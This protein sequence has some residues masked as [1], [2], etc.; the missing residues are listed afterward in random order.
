[1]KKLRYSLNLQLF[2]GEGEGVQGQTGVE[3]AA[4]EQQGAEG[5]S[6]EF[7]QLINGKFKSE[8]TKKTQAIIDKRFKS[9]KELEA[10]KQNVSPA[11]EMLMK[12]YGIP[13]GEEYRLS[14]A[15]SAEKE[16][17]SGKN[18]EAQHTNGVSSIKDRIASWIKEGEDF[19]QDLPDFNLRQELRESPMFS[20]L[21]LSGVP[22][23]AAYETVHRDEILSGAMRYTAQ[24]VREQVVK[25]IEAKGRRP[26]ENGVS[27]GVAVVTSVDVNS[28]TSQDII[29][30]LKQVENGASIK[31]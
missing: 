14:E 18:E 19:K 26:A 16:K 31:F 27:S 15:V 21:L 4:A 2:S 8:F 12:K 30:I 11:V 3:G 6:D 23:K 17:S 25:N 24:Q 5:S 28:L 1:M 20:K 22:L 29:K 9:T 13:P 7:S 10:Y